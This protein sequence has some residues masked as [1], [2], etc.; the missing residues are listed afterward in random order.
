MYPIDQQLNRYIRKTEAK[1]LSGL[2]AERELNAIQQAAVAQAARKAESNTII[3]KRG[4]IYSY[5]AR[6]KITTRKETE[7]I[8]ASKALKWVNTQESRA[9]NA[10]RNKKI[11]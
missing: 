10:L 9:H 3:Q 4:V 7:V 2:L 11:K 1:M 8:K 5:Q 6:N